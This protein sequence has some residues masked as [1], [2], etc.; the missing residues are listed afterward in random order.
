MSKHPNERYRHELKYI[1][2][3]AQMQVLQT[4]IQGILPLDSFAAETGSYTLRSMYF[5]DNQN[6][7]YFANENGDDPREKLRVRIYNAS[8]SRIKLECKRKERSKTLKHTCT[9]TREQTLSL[10]QGQ[11][12]MDLGDQPPLL[13]RLTCEMLTRQTKPVVI[14]EYDRIPYVY[15]LGNVRVTFDTNIAASTSFDAFFDPLL[16]KRPILPAGMH[17]MEVKFDE[18][19]PDFIYRALALENLQQTAFSKFYLC[20]KY[21][22]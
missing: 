18:F 1:I 9:L 19:L 15:P 12:V 7:A 11:P 22:L 14:V 3:Q 17:L 6:S 4:R 21:S 2:S 16:P 5:D 8:D 13:R 10:M 20:R